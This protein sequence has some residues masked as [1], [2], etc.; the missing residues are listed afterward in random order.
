MA[1]YNG[2]RTGDEVFFSRLIDV[3]LPGLE[4]IPAAVS[5][6]DY[7]TARR[8]FAAWV[9][10]S[11]KPHYFRNLPY[12]VY[13]ES[14][15]KSGET[16]RQSADRICAKSLISCGT[17]FQFG[18]KI[19]YF[20]NPTFNKYKE[21]TWQLSRHSE[22]LILAYAY[23]QTKDEKY[24]QACASQFNTWVK[25]A[26]SPEPKS[27]D[28][29]ATL[30][31]RTIEAGIRMGSTWQYTLHAFYE[32]PA[33]TDDIIVDWYKSVWEHGERLCNDY[34]TANWLLMEMDG[35]A[36]I[37][38]LYPVLRDSTRWYSFAVEMLDRQ[39]DLQFYPDGMQYELTTHY[40]GVSLSCYF[41]LMRVMRAY[42]K[43]VPGSFLGKLEN[44]VAWY[45]KPIMPDFRL[46]DLNDGTWAKAGEW[47]AE[48]A[49]FFPHRDDFKWLV[50][51]GAEG[52]QPD[53]VSAAMPYSG[54]AAMRTGWEKDASWGL[55][56]AGPFGKAHQHEDKLSFLLYMNGRRVLTEG[57]VYA[58]D[59]SPMRR[60]V[61]S[62]RSH[63][64]IRVN[65]MD[66]NRG[67]NYHWADEDIKK[68]SGLKYRIA[69]TYDFARGIY[70]EGYGPRAERL[71]A[72]ERSVIFIKKPSFAAKPFFIIIDRLRSINANQYE[73]LW[74]FDADSISPDGLDARA[75]FIHGEGVSVFCS[76][77]EGMTVSEVK[78][79]EE[80]EWQGW[81]ANSGLQGDYRPIP[82]L[83]YRWASG[84]ARVVTVFCPASCPISGVRASA[85][86]ADTLITLS[87][88][89]GESVTMDELDY[90]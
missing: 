7:R 44:A 28:G 72:H 49:E 22:W 59:D 47:V 54:L 35:L 86:T 30:C 41:R 56:D 1:S 31:W 71:T 43:S 57:G 42:G 68:E 9:R 21:W 48:Y 16:W 76:G 27:V 53:F 33:F 5:K 4:G 34:R 39:L 69:D 89:G 70:D 84:N 78:G 26:L 85:D 55:L 20:I 52:K 58:Y 61:L 75:N 80:P 25:Q 12:N 29:S 67:L 64:T 79:Q 19:D 81:A 60:Y 10:S 37:G 23:L 13:Q 82:T 63:N 83:C 32:S 51:E 50:T 3:T 24:A 6:E 17:E 77:A 62:T 8:L 2:P 65:G 38:I 14:V 74:H 18:E 15:V 87:L 90:C 40:H 88:R 66:Q 11:L 46:P 45:C 36:Q 73:S